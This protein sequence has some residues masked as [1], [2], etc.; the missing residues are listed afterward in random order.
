MFGREVQSQTMSEAVTP[1]PEEFALFE[2]CSLILLTYTPLNSSENVANSGFG[3]LGGDLGEELG[4][5]RFGVEERDISA[6]DMGD[7]LVDDLLVSL[8]ASRSMRR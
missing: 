3:L 7:T 5:F 2:F 6:E 4:L 1:F 8:C